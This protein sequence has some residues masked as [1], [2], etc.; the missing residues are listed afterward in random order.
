V[1]NCP[2][3][4]ERKALPAKL[5]LF[6][7]LSFDVI[8]GMD[9]LSKYV[10]NIECHKK[11]VIFWLHGIKEFRLCGSRVQATPPLTFA[12]QAI[13]SVRDG[14]QASL[15]YVQA[16]PEFH[17]KLKDIRVVHH[18]QDVF[19]E[20]TGLPPDREDEFTIDLVPGENKYWLLNNQVCVCVQQNILNAENKK[21]K[22]IFD[23]VETL[24]REKP[25]RDNQTQEFHYPKTK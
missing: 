5:A 25:L 19:T 11:E 12:I 18:Y 24:W 16:K 20:V 14:A 21:D 8:L 17:S 22:I 9:W 3:Y 4:I 15:A 6:R 7:M 13:K 1:D 23:E 2:V 10:V